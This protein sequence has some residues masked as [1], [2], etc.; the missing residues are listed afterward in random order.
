MQS[1]LAA[2]TLLGLTALALFHAPALAVTRWIPLPVPKAL[3]MDESQPR[4]NVSQGAV[5]YKNCRACHDIGLNPEARVGPDLTGIVGRP[6]AR[7]DNYAYSEALHAAGEEGLV[8]SPSL[9]DQYLAAPTKFLPGNKMAYVGLHDDQARRDLIAY[10]AT[11][12]IAEPA[13]SAEEETPTAPDGM[14]N[15]SSDQQP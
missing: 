6:A 14:T 7:L 1:M 5:V 10:L 13:P 9:L 8:W 11:F 4:P 12:E 3:A 15:P 2:K